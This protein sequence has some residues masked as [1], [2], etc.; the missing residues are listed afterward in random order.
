MTPIIH[1]PYCRSMIVVGMAAI[2]VDNC[3]TLAFGPP[4]WIRRSRGSVLYPIDGTI[5]V[6][7][8]S[9]RGQWR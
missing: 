2:S 7:E 6:I 3:V 1:G 5:G 8:S 9:P 4:V